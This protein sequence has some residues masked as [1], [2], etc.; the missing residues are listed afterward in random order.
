MANYGVSIP[1]EL[2]AEIDRLAAEWHCNR[3]MAFTRIYLEWKQQQ[4]APAA[5][6][7]QVVINGVTYAQI[8]LAEAA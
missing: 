2:S 8:G 5:A 1:D 4:P 6:P 7:R 3:S